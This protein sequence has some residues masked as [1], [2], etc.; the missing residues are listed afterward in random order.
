MQYVPG[1][2]H[3]SSPEIC[4]S[5]PS[6]IPLADPL[7]TWTPSLFCWCHY[8]LWPHRAKHILHQEKII[9]ITKTTAAKH[10]CKGLYTNGQEKWFSIISTNCCHHLRI[11]FVSILLTVFVILLISLIW[12][13]HILNETIWSVFTIYTS[14]TSSPLAHILERVLKTLLIREVGT[15]SYKSWQ[16][17]LFSA[18]VYFAFEC[19][20]L[21]GKQTFLLPRITFSLFYKNSFP[22][23]LSSGLQFHR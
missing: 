1:L 23:T 14:R 16:F 11:R 6:F 9:K 19:Y 3:L 7:T 17:L 2:F 18:T 10:W 15:Q 8:Y 5:V 21:A 13:Y 4:L 12:S 22:W 20:S